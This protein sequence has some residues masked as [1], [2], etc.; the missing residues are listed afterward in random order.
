MIYWIGVAVLYLCAILFVK[1]GRY[2]SGLLWLTAFFVEFSILAIVRAIIYKPIDEMDK[3][4][5]IKEILGD[6]TGAYVSFVCLRIC[7]ANLGAL[8]WDKT[9]MILMVAVV[10]YSIAFFVVR[11]ALKSRNKT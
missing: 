10:V 8:H 6:I 4:K 11:I 7:K 9:A 5:K 2:R 1:G 3:K